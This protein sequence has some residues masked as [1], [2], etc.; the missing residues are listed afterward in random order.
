MEK[1][2]HNFPCGIDCKKHLTVKLRGSKKSTLVADVFGV[3][4]LSLFGVSLA[5]VLFEYA[6]GGY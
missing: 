3:F 6:T 5:F 1:V 4:L 2:N